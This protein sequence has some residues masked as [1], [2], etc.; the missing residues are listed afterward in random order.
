MRS[1]ERVVEETWETPPI[2][3]VDVTNNFRDPL[4]STLMES[5]KTRWAPL[6]FGAP[7]FRRGSDSYQL[8]IFLA[9][10]SNHVLSMLSCEDFKPCEVLVQR[11]LLGDLRELDLKLA[12][13]DK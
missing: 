5:R 4:S 7:V 9:T 3:W 2:I 11:S 8:V 1:L 6:N 13:M 10:K 12:P